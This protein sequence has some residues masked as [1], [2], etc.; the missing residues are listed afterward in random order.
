MKLKQDQLTH[1]STQFSINKDASLPH[2]QF[3]AILSTE[4][5]DRHGEIV[6]IAGLEIPANQV[7]KMYYNHQTSGDALPIGKWLKV[8]KQD[9]KLMGL[10]QID[11]NDE[12]AALVYSKIQNGFI[13]S[14][15]IGF[16]PREYDGET[17]TWTKST[18]AEASVVAEPANVDAKITAKQL[19]FT[20][21]EFETKLK[22]RLAE[23]K[24]TDEP[25][26]VEV[27]TIRKG[28]VMDVLVARDKC[29]YME[30]FYEVIWAFEDAYYN[31]EVPSTDFG[32]LLT[33]TVG[34]LQTVADG[35]Y[36]DPED[37]NE[38]S[39]DDFDGDEIVL[40]VEVLNALKTLKSKYGSLEAAVKATSEKPAMKQIIRVRM[41]GKEVD[42]ASEDLNRVLKVTLKETQ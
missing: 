25:E 42:K 36:Q 30:D 8:W 21:E 5:L 31:P 22:V 16:F 14:I 33:E 4:T 24:Q 10:G 34:I 18:L 2:G 15:S 1:L 28:A 11:L 32:K 9:G 20:E 12:F 38:D 26:Q 3:E 41:A 7:I 39:E 19:G 29:D 27:K 37:D 17:S 23:I 13:D 40:P 6:S 35:T